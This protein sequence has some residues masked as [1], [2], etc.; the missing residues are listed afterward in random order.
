MCFVSPTTF[1]PACRCTSLVPQCLDNG[2]K[3]FCQS[4]PCSR[5]LR[6]SQRSLRRCCLWFT[7]CRWA[8]PCYRQSRASPGELTTHA[9]LYLFPRSQSRCTQA[10]FHCTSSGLI[11]LT[12]SRYG[13]QGRSLQVN[14][15]QPLRQHLDAY[16]GAVSE[17]SAAYERTLVEKSRVIRQTEK[18]NLNLGRKR[19]RGKIV[20]GAHQPI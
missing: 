4:R 13:I 2:L 6:T 15:E 5:E 7:G 1:V 10:P 16:K 19:H 17:R 12:L 9:C 14:C 20:L 3:R 11:S 8:P 18:E